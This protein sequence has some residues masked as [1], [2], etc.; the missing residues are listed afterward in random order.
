M[1]IMEWCCFGNKIQFNELK[2]TISKYIQIFPKT[3]IDV[4]S[5]V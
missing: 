1:N 3:R 5:Y 4:C 2:I